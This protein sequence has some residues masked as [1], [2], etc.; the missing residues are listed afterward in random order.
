MRRRFA[1][2][3]LLNWQFCSGDLIP[4]PCYA[5]RQYPAPPCLIGRDAKKCSALR[6]RVQAGKATA[7]KIAYVLD[8]WLKWIDIEADLG[9]DPHP[10]KIG[11][12][13]RKF[14]EA[15]VEL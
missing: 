11:W 12:L 14:E 1:R 2:A 8:C 10:A 15:G 6:D 3:F 5:T 13:E 4:C 7:D 9:N